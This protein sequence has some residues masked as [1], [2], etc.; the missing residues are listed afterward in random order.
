M[1]RTAIT[2]VAVLS[3]MALPLALAAAQPP[4]D[5]QAGA[6]AAPSSIPQADSPKAQAPAKSDKK[7]KAPTQAEKT[8]DEAI[9]KLR[10][11]ESATAN[12]VIKSDI[13]GQRFQ[14]QGEYAR[15]P[16]DRVKLVLA[17]SGLADASGRMLQICDGSTLWDFKEILDGQSYDRIDVAKVLEKLKDPG[18]DEE[19]RTSFRTQQ[20]GFVGPEALLESLRKSAGFDG[21]EESTFSDRPVWI[22]RGTWEDRES[23]HLDGQ[24][25]LSPFGMLPAYVPSAVSVWIDK[26]TGW[27]HQVKMD[28]QIPSVLTQVAAK[29]GADPKKA[30]AAAKAKDLAAQE[31]QPSH[32]L[33]TYSDV[34]VNPP[35]KPE[36]FAFEPPRR[37]SELNQVR[38]LTPQYLA[39]LDAYLNNEAAKKKAE[40]SRKDGAPAPTAAPAAP[41]APASEPEKKPQ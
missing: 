20:L 28:G 27:P 10:A 6:G 14:L 12:L 37:A 41:T 5:P 31:I 23:L 4:A 39:Y 9:A 16:Q 18:F 8:I 30:A 13:L 35:W 21:L 7:D 17:L 36:D 25:P 19:M 15:A 33:M 29:K 40:E 32:L 26:E 24:A 3:G 38:D 1:R 2:I 11:L 34:K 22:A